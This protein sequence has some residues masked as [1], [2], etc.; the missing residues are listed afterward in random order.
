METR[1]KYAAGGIAS[2]AA[3][4]GLVVAVAMSNSAALADVRGTAVGSGTVIVAATPRDAAASA[5]KS[6][7]AVAE[8]GAP[9]D[10]VAAPEIA[11]TQIAATE[12][13][14]T[15]I[16]V[17]SDLTPQAAETPS[18]QAPRV[19][20]NGALAALKVKHSSHAASAQKSRSDDRA[21]SEKTIEIVEHIVAKVE[22]SHS[23]A[24]H[25]QESSEESTAPTSSESDKDRPDHKA[26][27]HVS[28]DRRD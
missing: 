21:L 26:Q 8:A 28:P 22:D 10:I 20:S 25:E 19:E 1:A 11:V 27:S 2:V 24:A 3:S 16:A 13:A 4:V 15:E 7:E 5:P 17:V 18:A 9:S 12:I 6:Q 14:A 23:D